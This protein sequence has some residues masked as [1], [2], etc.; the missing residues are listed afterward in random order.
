MT[1]SDADLV[2]LFGI[3]KPFLAPLYLS[4]PLNLA[5]R[6]S[7]DEAAQLCERD[8][9]IKP[10]TRDTWEI[11]PTYVNGVL[12][13]NLSKMTRRGGWHAEST[14]MLPV[15]PG[16]GMLR[17]SAPL[18]SGRALSKEECRQL[19]SIGA[20]FKAANPAWTVKPSDRDLLSVL[21]FRYQRDTMILVGGLKLA[22]PPPRPQQPSSSVARPLAPPPRSGSWQNLVF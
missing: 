7:A 1:T 18:G 20:E 22:P 10:S 13:A 3:K 2:H 4:Y 8:S 5:R 9:A 14:W 11:A 16:E 12:Q 6:L 21:I 17:L 15:A 19:R